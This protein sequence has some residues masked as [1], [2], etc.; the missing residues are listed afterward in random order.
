MRNQQV[1][2]A[3][4][5]MRIAQHWA[6]SIKQLLQGLPKT[7]MYREGV[8]DLAQ[9]ARGTDEHHW[10]K[11]IGAMN[12]GIFNCDEAYRVISLFREMVSQAQSD[13][14]KYG[15]EA[16]K[17]D[18]RGQVY[19]TESGRAYWR[20]QKPILRR[21]TED[22]EQRAE[23]WNEALKSLAALLGETQRDSV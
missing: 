3:A 4:T 19:P 15:N 5:A 16:K 6:R 12:C 18:H 10:R 17:A 13:A 22:L 8:R 21:I 20:A 11:Q 14:K 2:V 9:G 1:R 7:R 23:E